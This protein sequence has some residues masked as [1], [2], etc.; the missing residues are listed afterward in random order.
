MKKKLLVVSCAA[1]LILLAACGQA[2]TA[3]ETAS[4]TEPAAAPTLDQAALDAAVAATVAAELT[5]IAVENPSPTPAPTNTPQPT[6]PP[7]AVPS[8]TATVGAEAL[9]NHAL[10]LADVTIPDGTQIAADTP[11][12]KTWRL[13]N[14]GFNTWTTDFTVVFVN[15]DRMEGEPINL[16]AGVPPG[17]TV[18]ITITMVAPSEAGTYEGYWMLADAD[19]KVFGLGEAADQAFLVSIVV[20]PAPTAT[21][22][23]APTETPAPTATP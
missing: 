21:P 20:L 17:G 16:P 10:F 8:P 5:R 13:Q 3:T 19:G 18:D 23:L 2:G 1:L 4:P 14:I 11:F 12:T 22:T 15:G 7:T 9:E 6:D